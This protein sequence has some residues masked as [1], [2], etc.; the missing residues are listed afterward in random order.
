MFLSGVT[1]S[2]FSLR[3]P[4]TT[5]ERISGRACL[6]DDQ[7]AGRALARAFLELVGPAAVVGHRVAAERLRI[8][9]ARIRRIRNRRVVDQHDD[10][11]AF[12]VDALEVVPVELRRLDAVAGEDQLG[13]GDRGGVFDV[14]GPGDDLVAPL[15]D[16]L[17]RRPC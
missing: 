16:L 15:D 3:F 14:F 17:R 5:R 1:R 9:L 12:D 4:W 10:R 11:L 7:H 8:E 13:V 2:N 6:V